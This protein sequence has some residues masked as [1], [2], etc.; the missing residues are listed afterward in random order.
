VARAGRQGCPLAQSLVDKGSARDASGEVEAVVPLGEGNRVRHTRKEEVPNTPM[1][2]G[3]QL[4]RQ[5]YERARFMGRWNPR[6]DPKA[7]HSGSGSPREEAN[8][9]CTDDI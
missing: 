5:V 3:R 7:E 1:S 8:P 9:V 4:R 2:W 6:W